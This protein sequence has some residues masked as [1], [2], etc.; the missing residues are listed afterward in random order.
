[1]PFV[2]PGRQMFWP[3]LG[4]AA[5]ARKWKGAPLPVDAVRPATQTVLIGALTGILPVRATPKILAQT[6]GYTNM[7]MSRAVD[8]IEANDLGRVERDGRERL[9]AFPQDRRELWRRALPYLRD[10]VHKTVRVERGSFPEETLIRA[11]ETALAALSMLAPPSEPVFALGRQ[12]W[13]EAT[14]L[15]QQVPVQDAGTCRVQMWRYDP[16][17]FARDRSVDR[18]SL[19]LSLRDEA[20]ERVGA[21][22]DEM[23]ENAPWS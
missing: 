4:L 10:P 9:L 14:S 7:T 21:A 3:E 2:V 19:Y 13:K 20:D 1:V 18:F 6:L 22:L 15:A 8:E 11:G 17:L 12:A 16:L 5:Q 23:M